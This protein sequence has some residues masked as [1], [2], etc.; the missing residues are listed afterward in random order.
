M[1]KF[2]FDVAALGGSL[3]GELWRRGSED[4]DEEEEEAEEEEEV[5]VAAK[6][7]RR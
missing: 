5:G 4:G 6:K 2:L 7:S 1:F 3:A